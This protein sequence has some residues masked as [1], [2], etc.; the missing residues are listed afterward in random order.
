[1]TNT[2]TPT[3]FTYEH[4]RKELTPDLQIDSAPKHFRVKSLKDANDQEGLLLGEYDYDKEGEPLQHFR[5]QNPDP[6]PTRYI[7]LIIQSNHGELQYTCLYRF[8]VHG[9]KY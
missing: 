8:R 4:I 1:M 3:S 6:I 5:V 7:E 2:I 9:I